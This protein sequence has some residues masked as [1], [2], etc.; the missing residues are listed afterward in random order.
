MPSW[1]AG[2]K[3]VWEE[4]RHGA[5]NLKAGR[6]EVLLDGYVSEDHRV[7]SAVEVLLRAIPKVRTHDDNRSTGLKFCLG[8]HQAFIHLFLAVHVFEHVREKNQI[9]V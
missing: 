8:S 2:S 4:S 7:I 1:K 5:T 9:E 6:V 3:R